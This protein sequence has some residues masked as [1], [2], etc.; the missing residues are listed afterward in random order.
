MRLPR[1]VGLGLVVLCFATGMRCT[2][3][4][5]STQAQSRWR[6]ARAGQD[7]R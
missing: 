3:Q 6:S 2:I 1:H 7:E 4:T 5:R